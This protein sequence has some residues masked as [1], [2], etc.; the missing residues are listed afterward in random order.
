ML[1]W[2]I[3]FYLGVH[4]DQFTPLTGICIVRKEG[5]DLFNDALKTFDLWLFGIRHMVKDPL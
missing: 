1:L 4:L 5:S 2:K 3:L